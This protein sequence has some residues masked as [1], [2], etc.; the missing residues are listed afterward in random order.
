MD[1]LASEIGKVEEIAYDPKVSQTK[2][3]IRALITFNT[4]NPAKAS[5]K[6]NVPQGGTVTIEFEYEKIHKRCF[7]CLRITHEKIKCPLWRRG[8]N[9]ELKSM[10]GPSSSPVAVVPPIVRDG[11]PGFP[12]LF[13]ELS[14]EDRKMAMLYISHSD[15]TERMA[16]IQR[17]RQGIA[18]NQ[19][20]SS[21]RL[22]RITKEL[23]KG[24][25]HV[26]SYKEPAQLLTAVPSG[27]L[28]LL[29]NSANESEDETESYTSKTSIY[30]APVNPTGFQLGSSSEGRVTGKQDLSKSQR[31]WPSSWKRK[32]LGR[33]S[34]TL[35][36]DTISWLTSGCG[37]TCRAVCK[38]KE[39]I[40]LLCRLVGKQRPKISSPPVASVLKPLHPQ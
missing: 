3:Y 8:N 39:K 25:G 35:G 6:L 36:F 16:R 40:S 21:T 34:N 30:S 4:N 11:P 26:F 28:A 32:A 23:D 18:D 9:R 13:P 22:I 12:N 31:K 5:R 27:R 10:E 38:Y 17:V 20:D 15:A 24:K 19:A 29:D 14:S 33:R 37:T 1:R 2:D 7:H